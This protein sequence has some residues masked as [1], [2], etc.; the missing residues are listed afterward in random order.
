MGVTIWE[1]DKGS[2]VWYVDV[3]HKGRRIKR[4]VGN[5][6]AAEEA[7]RLFEAELIRDPEG[8]W[9]KADPKPAEKPFKI[10]SAIW[11]EDYI[12]AVNRPTTHERYGQLLRDYINPA[13]GDQELAA[14]NRGDI[15]TM[16][17][18]LKSR[19]FSKS[20]ICVVKDVASGVFN[21]AIEDELVKENPCNG[22]LK[23][24][25][26]ERSGKIKM[27]PFDHV[28][29]DYCLSTC[30]RHFPDD[31]PFF[32]TAF[33]TGLRH[34]ELLALE[35]SDIDWFKR[36]LEVSKSFKNGLV[37]DPKNGKSRWV[38]ISDDLSPILRD[39][40]TRRKRE[41]LESGLGEPVALLFHR[42]GTHIA[43]N[44]IRNIFK[45]VL[46]KAGLRKIRVHDIRHTYVSL[47]LSAGANPLYV[48]EQAGH[49]NLQMTLEWYADYIP[50]GD[51]SEVN[52]LNLSG[53]GGKA[54]KVEQR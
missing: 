50:T 49:K 3:K 19:G 41:A 43:Q 16:L 6:K 9:R 36:R 35:W 39:L 48:S 20:H 53:E 21:Y 2:G 13:I 1:K 15:R 7:K 51:T 8:L 31:Y 27:F 28:E 25:G 4:K 54:G 37:G 47:L 46:K 44:T 17:L 42:N 30:R 45:R 24:L 10:Y 29:V 52:L 12:R 26:L 11:L 40:L 22:I 23:R 18:D 34:G 14:I 38:D 33:S 32:M 5:R